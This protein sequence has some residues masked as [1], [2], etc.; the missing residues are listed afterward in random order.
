MPR[1]HCQE[2]TV[3]HRD[4]EAQRKSFS[5]FLSLCL[6][7]S[8][9]DWF[10]VSFHAA[11]R[12]NITFR[13]ITA[14]AGIHFT[15]N[16]GAF[17]KKWLPE[18][19]GP[20]CAFIDYD[21]DGWPDI[22]LVNGTDWPGHAKNGATTLK[23]YHNNHDGTFTDVTRKAGLAVSFFGLGVAVGDYDNDGFDDIFITAVGQSHLF[24][25][26][27]NGTFTDV[28]KSAGLWGPNE[29]STSAAWVDYDRDGKLDLVVANYV[30]WSEKGDLYCTLDGVAQILLHAGIVQGN[31]GAAVA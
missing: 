20:G 11:S 23:L 15:H 13:D 25:N 17:G 18:T 2:V 28:T 12:E 26:N 19:M 27:G 9:V 30:Q 3:H 29:F 22:L 31:F 7:D 5:L 21:N 8:V 14:Q 10:R 4:T 6:C 16:N 1:C 24:H